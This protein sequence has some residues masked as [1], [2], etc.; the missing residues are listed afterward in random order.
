MS[1]SKGVMLAAIIAAVFLCLLTSAYAGP[2]LWPHNK[3]EI[4]LRLTSGPGTGNV[5]R[6]AVMRTV[7]NH[8]IIH[9]TTT[10]VS[11]PMSLFS[12]NAVVEGDTVSFHVSSGGHFT[13]GP[14]PASGAYGFIDR[15]ELSASTLEGWVVGVGI[16]CP[17]GMCGFAYNPVQ[18]FAHTTCP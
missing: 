13:G 2:G 1:R 8:Y 6:M 12:G 16:S 3:G 11:G 18:D 4:C 14:A 9:G 15:G 17:N 10:E 5:V 7:G